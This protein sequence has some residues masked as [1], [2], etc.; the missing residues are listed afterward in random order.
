M[1]SK[2]TYKTS[3]K[4]IPPPKLSARRDLSIEIGPRPWIG[5][6]KYRKF[7]VSKKCHTKTSKY[8]RYI[9]IITG[10]AACAKRLRYIHLSNQHSRATL[11]NDPDHQRRGDEYPPPWPHVVHDSWPSS[12]DL[13]KNSSWDQIRRDW[14]DA[15]SIWTRV[16]QDQVQH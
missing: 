4:L 5:P 16:A 7:K 2:S 15:Q 10:A 12:L 9:P 13:E 14:S 1:S 8:T 6:K 11:I 3:Q